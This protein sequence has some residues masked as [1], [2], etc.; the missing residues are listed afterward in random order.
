MVSVALLKKEHE[1]DKLIENHACLTDDIIKRL[2]EI[3][4]TGQKRISLFIE[5]VRDG[6]DNSGGV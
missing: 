4:S 3:G 1:V 5:E 2:K 6:S